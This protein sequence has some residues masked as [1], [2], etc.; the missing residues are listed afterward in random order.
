MNNTHH[1]EKSGAQWLTE[2]LVNLGVSNIYGVAGTS[3][4][5]FL[6]SLHAAQ[7]HIS[8]ISCRHEQTA[9]SMADAEGRITGKPGVT[10]V[11]A[12]GGTLNATISAGIARKD[13]SPMIIICGR[14]QTHLN[15][16]SG[17]MDVCHGDVFK[18]LVKKTI[19]VNNVE[20]MSRACTDA[21]NTA[22][23][24]EKGPVLLEIP[25][26]LWHKKSSS[27][28]PAENPVF[29]PTFPDLKKNGDI[30]YL[31]ACLGKAK[32]PLILSG[33]GVAY[34]ESSKLLR[35]FATGWEIPVMTTGNGKGTFPDSHP[36]AL[37][38]LG[39]GGGAACAEKAYAK[40][41]LLLCLGCGLSDMSTYEFSLKS[42]AKK[43]AITLEQGLEH[44]PVTFEKIIN[45][46]VAEILTGLLEKQSKPS[47]TQTEWTEW[48]RD[49]RGSWLYS[50]AEKAV[51][52]KNSENGIWYFTYTLNKALEKSGV[53]TVGAGFHT[54][55]LNN[56]LQR[57]HPLGYLASSNAGTM[58]FGLPAAMAAK[59]ASPERQV[60]T[61]LGDGDFMMTLQ[62]LETIKRLN[63]N[64][65]IFVI[66]D[67]AYGIL[68]WKQT[69]GEFGQSYGTEHSNPD[70]KLLSESFGIDYECFDSYGEET[71]ERLES[72]LR[73]ENPCLIECKA[74]Y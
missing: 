56:Y 57:E 52:T 71:P 2:T 73:R 15:N 39:F 42:D 21:W 14:V 38:R 10:L 6:P 60:I 54:F 36:L 30:E 70:F 1:R 28:L 29:Q 64:I 69:T 46:D 53:V 5:G 62:E 20:D 19:L 32:R 23:E 49:Q 41:D 12:G 55:V 48:C 7:D 25:E 35:D 11:H 51:A 40:A 44:R 68:K 58:G 47:E 43:I 59:I 72:I 67:N 3:V 37:G 13:C 31:L 74:V 34:S 45:S 18:T 26:D 50:V 22:I 63:L 17:M 9:A 8:Y 66:N 4:L 16:S 61:F 27:Q 33:A 24:G 65:K